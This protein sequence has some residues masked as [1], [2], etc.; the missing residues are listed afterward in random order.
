MKI[1]VITD[2]DLTGSGYMNLTVPILKGLSKNGHEIKVAGLSYKGD[3]H[4][5]DFSIIP[6]NN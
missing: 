4:W 2:M 1:A 3:E 6:A 5:W